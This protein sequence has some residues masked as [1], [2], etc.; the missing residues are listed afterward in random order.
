MK[1]ERGGAKERG[2]Q[3]RWGCNGEGGGGGKEKE[4][5]E[6]GRAIGREYLE[7]TNWVTSVRIHG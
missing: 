5:R 4:W 2:R 7:G 6:R 3:A 1:G